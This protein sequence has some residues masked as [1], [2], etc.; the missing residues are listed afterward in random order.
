ML[1]VSAAMDSEKTAKALN[2]LEQAVKPE[3]IDPIIERE[4]WFTL[5]R[6]VNKT[7]RKWF[8]QVKM[9]WQVEK[10]R[11]GERIVVNRN[12][13]MKFLEHGTANGGTG[14]IYPRT[15]KALFIPLNRKAAGGWSPGLVM[16]RMV[17]G[18][19]GWFL[20]K[21]DYILAKRVRGIKP[22]HIV[23]SEA[24]EVKKRLLHAFKEHIRRAIRRQ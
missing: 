10:P 4:A 7:P 13:V 12:K 6:L 17:R 24:A 15:K 23:K 20:Q 16:Q 22:M 8:G 21:G 9:G 3:A 11:T 14:Y 1:Q 2:A 5:H 19:L 18:A